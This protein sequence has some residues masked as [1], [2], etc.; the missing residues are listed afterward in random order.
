VRP[1][2]RAAVGSSA[3]ASSIQCPEGGDAY[4]LKHIIHDWEDEDATRIEADLG[5]PN[6]APAA[7]FADLI[8]G[9]ARRARAHA[10]SVR[11]AARIGGVPPRENYTDVVELPRSFKVCPRQGCDVT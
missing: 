10:R 6:D 1:A 9:R 2:S 5:L 3:G 11:R 7:E 8:R 4:I